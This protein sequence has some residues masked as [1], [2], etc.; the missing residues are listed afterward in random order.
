MEWVYYRVKR[1][2]VKKKIDKN[3][4]EI[5]ELINKVFKKSTVIDITINYLLSE[6]SEEKQLEEEHNKIISRELIIQNNKQIKKLE[7]EAYNILPDIIKT[8]LEPIIK[9]SGGKGEDFLKFAEVTAHTLQTYIRAVSYSYRKPINGKYSKRI[10]EDNTKI[11]KGI[12]LIE[13]GL[14]SNCIIFFSSKEHQII[15]QALKYLKKHSSNKRKLP[16][17][18]IYN[19]NFDDDMKQVCDKINVASTTA[20]KEIK[21]LRQAIRREIKALH[22]Q[23]SQ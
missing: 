20:G 14:Y 17:Q 18:D 22:E 7:D 3:A 21:A 9:V 19:K 10:T 4:I 15:K 23:T 13:N 12:T 6:Y 8:Y 5:Q 11:K 2:E 1:Q 16:T